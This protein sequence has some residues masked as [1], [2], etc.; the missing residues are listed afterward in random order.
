MLGT[1]R[2]LGQSIG[3]ALAA[4][5]FGVVAADATVWALGIGSAIALLAAVVSVTR[6]LEPPAA[7]R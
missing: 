1:A 6:L 3:A 2:L 4:L 7:E 5:M